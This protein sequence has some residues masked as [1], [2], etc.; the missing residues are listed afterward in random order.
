MC[1]IACHSF[2]MGRRAVGYGLFGVYV[3]LLVVAIIALPFPPSDPIYGSGDNGKTITFGNLALRGEHVALRIPP[4]DML[5]QR[6]NPFYY[7]WLALR[8]HEFCGLSA[9]AD[10]SS[11]PD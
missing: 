5:R 3:T 4:G 7:S 6:W 11:A 1:E 8:T 9:P 2:T 10:E